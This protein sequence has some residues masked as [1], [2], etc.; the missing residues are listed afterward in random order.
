MNK[1]C[2]FSF[3]WIIYFPLENQEHLILLFHVCFHLTFW[4]GGLLPTS[5]GCQGRKVKEIP[6]L[7][8]ISED[9]SQLN[10]IEEC[11]ESLD[12]V[13]QF[14]KGKNKGLFKV[15]QALILK[16]IHLST[17]EQILG[18]RKMQTFFKYL[19]GFLIPIT[20]VQQK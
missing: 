15:L 6:L 16:G 14:H 4:G 7:M 18:A 11:L 13:S 8:E 17:V 10:T 20:N 1:M 5:L 3:R 12:R 2:S 9:L 19:T